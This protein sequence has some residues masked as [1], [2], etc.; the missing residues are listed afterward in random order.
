[1]S[2]NPVQHYLAI[3][4]TAPLVCHVAKVQPGGQ[5]SE[6]KKNGERVAL[7]GGGVAW[8]GIKVSIPTLPSP[9]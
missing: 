2:D 5:L 9:E 1:L 8:P 3:P 7:C 4:E 6:Y